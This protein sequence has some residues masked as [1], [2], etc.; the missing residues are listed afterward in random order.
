MSDI[1]IRDV[2]LDDAKRLLEIYAYYV[3]NTAITFEYDV[4]SLEEFENRIKNITKKYP[5][6]VAVKDG[7]IVGYA[8][9][10]VF[11]DRRAYDYS[12]ELTIYL[13]KDCT[14]SGVGRILYT[15][16]ENRLKAI[17]MKNLYACIGVPNEED[18]HLTNNSAEFHEHMGYKLCGTFTNCGYKF[19]KWYSM[20]WMEKLIGDHN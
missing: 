16:L 2:T 12:T 10:S 1:I 17:G 7:K 11:K 4:P 6:I 8:Y 19:G 20:V 14:K 15:E 18:E 5:Y 13:D 3:E 9:S